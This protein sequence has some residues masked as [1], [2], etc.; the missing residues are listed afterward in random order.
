MKYLTRGIK[1]S[2]GEYDYMRGYLNWHDIMVL[3]ETNKYKSYD[4][5]ID[6]FKEK[7]IYMNCQAE[8]EIATRFWEVFTSLNYED[9]KGYLNLVSGKSRIGDVK[10]RYAMDHRIRVESSMA[11]DEIPKSKPS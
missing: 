3:A 2:L 11:E 9:K 4:Q 10:H 1:Q 6:M 7:T 8:D 5:N